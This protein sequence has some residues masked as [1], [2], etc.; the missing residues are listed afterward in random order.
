VIYETTTGGSGVL[1][2]LNE[3]GCLASTLARARELLHDT[4]EEGCEKACYECLLS[5]YNQRNHHL[6]DRKPVLAWLKSLG[7]IEL[8]AEQ[9]G[10][11]KRFEALLEATQSELEREV[12]RAIADREMPLPDAGQKRLYDQEGVP[13]AIADFY[14]EPKIVVFVDGSPHYRDY[15]QASD[16]E[17]RRRLRGLGYRIVVI[18]AENLEAGLE[19][20]ENRVS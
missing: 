7:E 20:L 2:S 4:E 13:V 16:E 5:F 14:Y 12:L 9:A 3:P 10:E 1:A 8:Q 11:E 19:E 6:L 15:I 18:K 17:K